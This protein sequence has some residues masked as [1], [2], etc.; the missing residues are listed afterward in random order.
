[1][2]HGD[3]NTTVE[4]IHARNH[5]HVRRSARRPGKGDPHAMATITARTTEHSTPCLMVPLC[6]E[7]TNEYYNTTAHG[8]RNHSDGNSGKA[9]PRTLKKATTQ[10]VPGD[11]GVRSLR[12]PCLWACLALLSFLSHD[13]GSPGVHGAVHWPRDQAD[14]PSHRQ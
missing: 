5:Q 3:T 9:V 7:Q 12:L 13:G 14:E 4:D 6:T 1:M 11:P 2:K 10:V 8:N